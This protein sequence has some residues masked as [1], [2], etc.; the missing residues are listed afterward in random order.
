MTQIETNEIRLE[1]ILN[2]PPERVRQ[3]FLDRDLLAQWFAPG[4][5][6]A[7]VQTLD[8]K[9]GGQYEI[10]MTGP[11]PDGNESTHTATGTFTAIEDDRIEMRFNWSE[12]PLP[13]DTTLT[14]EF[15]PHE[16][17]T[18][19]VFIHSG[20]PDQEAVD[21]HTQGWEACL[22]KLQQAL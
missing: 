7:A 22:D 9:V 20:F 4:P 5:M 1:R 15:H 14:A 8:T 17:G 21:M 19:L 16:D 6:T 11:D 10:A 3:A 2:A 12:Q 13:N 18:R